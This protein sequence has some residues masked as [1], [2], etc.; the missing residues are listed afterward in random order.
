MI[1]SK[2]TS[3]II[4]RVLCALVFAVLVAALFLIP[5]AVEIYVRKDTA[6]GLSI[7][8]LVSLYTATVPAFV[9]IFALNKLLSNIG[10]EIVFETQNVNMLRILSWCCFVECAV[11]AV[12]GVYILVSFVISFAAAFLGVILRVVKN[13]IEEAVALKEE[14]SL[15]I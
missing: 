3:V 14:N 11:F 1:V 15:T 7:P 6:S 5:T 12:F 8:C 4:S 9:A 13:V 2:N 10:K